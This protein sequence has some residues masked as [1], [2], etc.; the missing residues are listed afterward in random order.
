MHLDS[1]MIN[2]KTLIINKMQNN[3]S[4]SMKNDKPTQNRDFNANIGK[5][6]KPFIKYATF[7]YFHTGIIRKFNLVAT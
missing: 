6:I 5:F 3:L 4:K 2:K 1:E 7:Y